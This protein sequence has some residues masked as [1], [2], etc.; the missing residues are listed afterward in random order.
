[1]TYYAREHTDP[2][3]GAL[4]I[5]TDQQGV[6]ITATEGR[7]EVTV[8]P[9]PAAT[10][11][12]DM[13]GGVSAARVEQEAHGH[14]YA[15]CTHETDSE[16]WQARWQEAADQRDARDAAAHLWKETARR[17]VKEGRNYLNVTRAYASTRDRA[18]DAL[19]KAEK[20]RDE[21]RATK[22]M[23]KERADRERARADAAAQSRPLTAD[24][25]TDEMIERSKNAFLSGYGSEEE[26][27]RAILRAALTEPTRPEGA[28]ELDPIVDEFLT[29]YW[30]G[31]IDGADATDWLASRG[32]RVTGAES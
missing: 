9:F 28:K 27:V 22:N 29:S 5:T 3:G 11:G 4:T 26:A 16:H 31:D 30:R 12:D 6:W 17:A 13:D 10:L 2:A 21:A 1:M 20:E 8:G 14:D 32:V 24:D 7:D 25:I 15:P 19:V 23:H 18:V